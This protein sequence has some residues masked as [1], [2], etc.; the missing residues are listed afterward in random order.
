M[1]VFFSYLHNLPGSSMYLMIFFW[2][3]LA[4]FPFSGV[5]LALFSKSLWATKPFLSWKRKTKKETQ[6]NDFDENVQQNGHFVKDQGENVRKRC[7][8]KMY[9]L[10]STRYPLIGRN[11]WANP[12]NFFCLFF[13]EYVYALIIWEE[14]TK[15]IYGSFFPFLFK[16]KFF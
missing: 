5:H 14:H 10:D 16:R 11:W 2:N 9:V 15:S 6:I 3:K 8:W 4:T 7:C 1:T 13:G 12:A